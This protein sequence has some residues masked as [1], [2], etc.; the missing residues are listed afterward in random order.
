[1][2]AARERMQGS[3]TATTTAEE[4]A[5]VPAQAP[6]PA[7]DPFAPPTETGRP[8]PLTPDVIPDPPATPRAETDN[9]A[10]SPEERADYAACERALDHY[11][12]ATWMY[13]KALQ[14]IR[15]SRYYREEF[16]T[17]VEFLEVRRGISESHAHRF[18]EEWPLAQALS[19]TLGKPAVQNHVTHLLPAAKAYG[20]NVALDY[21]QLMQ[22][23]AESQGVRLVGKHVH[24]L[25]RLL[26]AQAGRKAEP[27]QLQETAQAI[28][29][30]AEELAPAPITAPADSA[31]PKELEAAPAARP[32]RTA[33]HDLEAA[34][35]DMRRV[36]RALRPSAV[37]QAREEDQERTER[38]WEDLKAEIRSADQRIRRQE[39]KLSQKK[40]NPASTPDSSARIPDA[41]SSEDGA[42]SNG[43]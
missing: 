34:L 2:A 6:A 24:A 32:A 28:V 23:R 41:E 3:S 18:I 42:A 14:A 5:P 22:S 21:Y 16:G 8:Q 27:D 9:S 37:Q 39:K 15:D 19:Q 31:S 35:D 11:S 20:I 38:I 7:V 36:M 30:A 26:I 13:G 25:V 40:Q 29:Q 1:M 33:L 10:L 43:N 4:P 17:W 12:Q